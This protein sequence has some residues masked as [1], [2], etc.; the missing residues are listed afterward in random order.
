MTNVTQPLTEAPDIATL[1]ERLTTHKT[2]GS[3][4]RSELEWVARNGEFRRYE[5]GAR[6]VGKGEP[7]NE[8]IVQLSGRVAVT[9]DR[10][11]G[12]RTI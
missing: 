9:M 10:G 11:N 7:V 4:P 5:A 12:R 8:M 1:V 3:A 6:I 2:L